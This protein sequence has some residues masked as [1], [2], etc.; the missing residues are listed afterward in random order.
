MG[1]LTVVT[2]LAVLI[3]LFTETEASSFVYN[4][5][6]LRIIGL[7]CTFLMVAGG[8]GMLL[9]TTATHPVLSSQ[10]TCVQKSSKDEDVTALKSESEPD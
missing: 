2:V 5:E 1:N 7:V 9:F 6:R 8:V 3:S 10:I 4:Y